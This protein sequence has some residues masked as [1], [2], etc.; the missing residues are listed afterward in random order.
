MQLLCRIFL[1]SNIRSIQLEKPWAVQGLTKQVQDS[2][3]EIYNSGEGFKYIFKA[4]H[5]SLN[6]VRTIIKKRK[7]YGTTA[8]LQRT[9]RHPEIDEQKWSGR[10]SRALQ[11]VFLCLVVL[12]AFAADIL[13]IC[14]C[15]VKRCDEC[16]CQSLIWWIV[17]SILAVNT[18]NSA[19]L[20]SL[21][22]TLERDTAWLIEK[23][24]VHV[25]LHGPVRYV[26]ACECVINTQ[27]KTDIVEEMVK[28][29]Y[30]A[31]R[32]YNFYSPCA[33]HI[34]DPLN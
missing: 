18:H 8:R 14:M 27:D 7:K 6:T 28:V 15:F 29:N 3:V 30:C 31:Q 33:I 32:A 22:R 4:L 24:L 12:L 9:G 13:S 21:E 16:S 2:S 17:L 1:T 25:C 23:P 20:N 10:M 5:I 34:M 26:R 19:P 11:Q